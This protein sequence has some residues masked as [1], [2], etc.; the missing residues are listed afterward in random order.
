MPLKLIIGN[1]N[2]SSWSMRP[3]L[4][5]RAAG[6]AFEEQRIAIGTD[7]FKAALAPL[8]TAGRVP[9]LVDGEIPVWD[10]LAIIEHVAETHPSRPLW[11][12][13]P[14]ARAFAR[15]VSAEMHASFHHLR[16]HL[17]MN[18]WRPVELRDLP[19]GVARDVARVTAIFREARQRFGG[20]GDFLFG[21]FCAADAMFAPV[22][23]RLRTY[24]VPLDE[25]SAAY[26]AAVHAQPDFVAWKAEALRESEVLAEDE[27]DWPQVKR[28]P[29]ATA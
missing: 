24:A 14:A 4:A 25:V 12:A 17:P 6:I 21:A 15:S 1:K 16:R 27:V 26:V 23:T 9:V 13:R 7:A 19:E 8:G 18:L 2:Y 29:A 28:E 5:L 22:A 3:W 20:G 10:S 11:P